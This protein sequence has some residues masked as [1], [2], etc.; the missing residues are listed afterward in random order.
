MDES[1]VDV[2]SAD[3]V[4]LEKLRTIAYRGLPEDSHR[5]RSIT[6]SILLSSLPTKRSSWLSVLTSRRQLY[7]DYVKDFWVEAPPPEA[8]DFDHPLSSASSSGYASYFN[9]RRLL[10]DICKDLKRTHSSH[11]FFAL[12]VS[13]PSSSTS[14]PCVEGPSVCAKTAELVEKLSPNRILLTF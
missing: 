14:S 13:S 12:N 10:Y 5:L 7:C 6:W 8:T 1:L 11:P 2:L 9:D 4:S 3:E